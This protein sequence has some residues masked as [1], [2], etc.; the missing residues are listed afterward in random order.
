MPFF[1][2]IVPLYNKE[3][4]IAAT[5]NSALAQTFTDFEIVIINDGSTDTSEA[6]VQQFTDARIRYHATPNQK[7]S[8]ARNTGITMATGDVIAFLDADDYWQPD[9]LQVLYNL[10]KQNPTAG[11]LASRYSIKIG[12]G[13]VI[14]PLFLDVDDDYS[15]I[16]PDSFKA[17]LVNRVAV[18]S[19]VAVP[20]KVFETTGVFNPDVTHP[21]DTEL[22]VKISLKFPV[23]ISNKHTMIY[24]FDLPDSWSRKQMAGRKIMDFNQFLNDESNNKSLKAFLDLYRL[25]YA[26]KFRIEGDIKCS[27]DLYRQVAPENIQTKTRFLFMLPPVLLQNML[28]LKHWLHKKGISFSV[29]N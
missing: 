11:L 24:N 26:L 17:S 28:K 22:W 13:T 15:G 6:V 27:T 5:L 8:R 7:V 25:E 20:K 2:V 9:H 3:S 10:H 29:Y 14:Q 4:L 21:E 23:A 16:L 1:S 12:N 19:A 18:T